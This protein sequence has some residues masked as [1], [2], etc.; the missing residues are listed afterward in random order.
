MLFVWKAVHGRQCEEESYTLPSVTLLAHAFLPFL[1]IMQKWLEPSKALPLLGL[2]LMQGPL[3]VTSAT[4]VT[5]NPSRFYLQFLHQKKNNEKHD[6][7]LR[8]MDNAGHVIKLII[9]L[10]QSTYR[11]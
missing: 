11:G 5:H 3:G 7:R 4:A 9:L 8:W 1:H 2:F 6:A 10:S